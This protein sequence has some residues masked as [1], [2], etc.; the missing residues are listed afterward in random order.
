MN[1]NSLFFFVVCPNKL[2]II[3]IYLLEILEN[4]TKTKHQS[5]ILKANLLHDDEKTNYPEHKS[6]KISTSFSM[7]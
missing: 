3:F 4:S 1:F 5:L 6:N 2:W 7:I